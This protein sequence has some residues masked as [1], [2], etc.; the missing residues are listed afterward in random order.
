MRFLWASS[1][2]LALALALP[3]AASAKW[4]WTPDTGFVD[5]KSYEETAPQELY[6]KAKGIYDKSKFDDAATEFLRIGEYCPDAGIKEQAYYMWPESL[7]K[8][9]KFYRAWQAY[10]EYLDR[11]PRTQLLKEIIKRELECGEAMVKGAKKDLLGVYILSGRS[12]GKEI[13][14]KVIER[15]PYEEICSQYRLQL[16]NDLYKDADF[17]DAS[18]Q[19]DAFVKDYPDSAFAPTALYQ[20][21]KAQ[22]GSHEGPDY[23]SS[24]LN[25]AKKTFKRYLDENPN[26]DRTTE[27]KKSLSEIED[28]EAEKDFKTALFYLQRD[29]KPAAV[30]YL[31]GIQ[32]NYRG[33]A[34]AEKAAKKLAELEK[35]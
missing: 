26:G 21:G 7:F 30:L 5:T 35:N 11:Y 33:S 25:E 32:R 4:V 9:G 8:A 14:Q 3:P 22:L 15:F 12:T 13:I 34:W 24:P 20:K 19:Y 1:L 2:V 6:Q 16:A 29:R 18:V 31:K 23:D 28:R 10:E 27:V 17:E